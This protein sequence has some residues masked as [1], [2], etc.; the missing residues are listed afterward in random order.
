MNYNKLSNH[1]TPSIIT[2]MLTL[3]MPSFCYA[4]G[5]SPLINFFSEET[6]KS[7]TI[8]LVCIILLES[9]IL[10]RSIKAIS[11]VKHLL[12]STIINII[13][14]AAGSLLILASGKDK[15]YFWDTTPLV[16]P[17]FFITLIVE[18][19]SIKLLYKDAIT[20][21]RSIW[22]DLKINILSYLLVFAIQLSLLYGFL[23]FANYKDKQIEKSGHTLRF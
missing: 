6:Y 8:V 5:V 3:S 18:F 11:Y 9:F 21:K 10:W 23:Y 1:F 16:L 2:F 14:S 12:F 17:L 13:S 7:A 4:D 22:I 20:W 15:F 19:P